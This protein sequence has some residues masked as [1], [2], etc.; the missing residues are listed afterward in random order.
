ML[1]KFLCRNFNIEQKHVNSMVDFYPNRLRPKKRKMFL[2]KKLSGMDASEGGG[3]MGTE[4][5][6]NFLISGLIFSL[7]LENFQDKE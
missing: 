6:H 3:E 7:Y 4:F 2:I 5:G 1:H